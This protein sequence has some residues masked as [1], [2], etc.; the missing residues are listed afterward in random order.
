MK[1]TTAGVNV[2]FAGRRAPERVE[3]KGF[4]SGEQN[5]LGI[6]LTALCLQG[7]A[8]AILAWLFFLHQLQT[9]QTQR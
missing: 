1:L 6:V 3:L 8:L 7:L 2:G 9:S 5:L 4:S